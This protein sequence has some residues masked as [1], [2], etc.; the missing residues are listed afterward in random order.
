MS[1]RKSKETYVNPLMRARLVKRWREAGTGF[2]NDWEYDYEFPKV[3]EYG[4]ASIGDG[5]DDSF[6]PNSSFFHEVLLD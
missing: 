1:D 3:L 2:L 5:I 6:F 4:S